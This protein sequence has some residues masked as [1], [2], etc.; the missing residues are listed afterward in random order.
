MSLAHLQELLDSDSGAIKDHRQSQARLLHSHASAFLC[1]QADQWGF[2]TERV[3]TFVVALAEQHDTYHS[4]CKCAQ[5][6]ALDN[7]ESFLTPPD[8]QTTSKTVLHYLVFKQLSHE[9]EISPH[10]I[11]PHC[12]VALV[13]VE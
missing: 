10:T 13:F 8:I 4:K 3:S 7:I 5:S 12:F 6:L 1:N 9:I 2:L 11:S